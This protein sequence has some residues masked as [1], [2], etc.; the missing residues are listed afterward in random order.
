[1]KVVLPV[2]LL[3]VIGSLLHYGGEVAA[4]G[5]V[6]DRVVIDLPEGIDPERVPVGGHYDIYSLVY[7]EDGKDITQEAEA[8]WWISRDI[9]SWRYISN[10]GMRLFPEA[11]GELTIHTRAWVGGVNVTASLNVTLVITI[12]SVEI[13]RSPAA[14]Y[15]YPGDVLEV[16][17]ELLDW[18]GRPINSDASYQWNASSGTIEHG[19]DPAYVSW[20]AATTGLALISVEYSLVDQNGS[21]SLT[22]DVLS[23]ISTVLIDDVPGKLYSGVYFEFHVTVLD[24][25]GGDVTRLARVRPAV[26]VE[27]SLTVIDWLWNSTSGYMAIRSSQAG[28][29]T[30]NVRAELNGVNLTAEET[31]VIMEGPVPD[32]PSTDGT[33]NFEENELVIISIVLM[34]ALMVAAVFWG[35][36]EALEEFVEELLLA[37]AE[38]DDG[39][40]LDRLDSMLLEPP[41]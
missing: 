23:R 20:T 14:G 36:S 32:E 25:E 4:E 41:E 12:E 7:D 33:L 28:N 39:E 40:E 22:V 17:V 11:V 26:L 15:V 38:E 9:A 29:A 18:E 21:A 10:V 35:R 24:E 31:V 16:H 6:P 27:G 19:V 5:A 30:I 34:V 8:E 37:D 13:V 3:I 2:V 1:V